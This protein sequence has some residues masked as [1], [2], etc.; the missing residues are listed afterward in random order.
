MVT[1]LAY[2]TSSELGRAVFHKGSCLLASKD[3]GARD[4]PKQTNDC[5]LS[6]QDVVFPL[7]FLLLL[8]LMLFSCSRGKLPGV[9]AIHKYYGLDPRRRVRGVMIYM[10]ARPLTPASMATSK[11]GEDCYDASSML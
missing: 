3:A 9:V 7:K 8:L 10:Y 5:L 4:E 2:T 11:H 1:A 6:N